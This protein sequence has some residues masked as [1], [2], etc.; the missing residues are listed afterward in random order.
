MVPSPTTPTVLISRAIGRPSPER[1]LSSCARVC[2]VPARGRRQRG[3]GS[4]EAMTDGAWRDCAV[5]D[6]RSLAARARG[7]RWLPAVARVHDRGG[8]PNSWTTSASRCSSR[9]SGS[10]RRRSGRP[11]RA[12]TPSR[13]P[14]GMGEAESLVWAWKDELPRDGARLVR[15][16]P[17]SGAAHCSRR[18][19]SPR[20]TP[21]RRRA[22]RPP[23]IDLSRQAHE[24]AEAL[25]GG[26]LTTAALRQIVGDRSRYERAIGELHRSLLVT[27]GRRRG[28]AQRLAGGHR[29]PDLPDLRRR[30]PAGSWVRGAARSSTTMR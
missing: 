1:S 11:S 18:R 19:C 23:A 29:R 8:R 4:P 12:R 6:R 16:V 26:P 14:T 15:Q 9:P 5:M 21:G 27:V 7:E 2:H 10:R 24:I 3:T 28:T 17:L 22:D 30:R 25:P 13:S 20:S